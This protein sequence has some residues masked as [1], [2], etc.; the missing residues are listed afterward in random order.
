MDGTVELGVGTAVVGGVV[1]A[2]DEV[3]D[4]WWGVELQA[5]STLAVAA[6]KLTDQRC[7]DATARSCPCRALVG[8]REALALQPEAG[9]EPAAVV[10][11]QA[12]PT[13]HRNDARLRRISVT[14]AMSDTSVFGP[15]LPDSTSFALE[16]TRIIR[17]R[18]Q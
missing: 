17:H 9:V 5:A 16:G 1:T 7:R 18:S 8:I 3:V 13:V 15:L 4:E 14:F 10:V 11:E 2:A 12:G 6:A